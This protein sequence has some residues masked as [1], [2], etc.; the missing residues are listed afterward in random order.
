MNPELARTPLHD[1][2]QAHH[3]RMVE[4]GGW[5]MPVQYQSIMEEH[6]AVRTAVGLFDV[7]HMGRLAFTGP[8]AW[9]FLDRVLTRRVLDLPAGRVR[10]SLVTATSG[11]ILDDVLVY[12][13]V[14]ELGNAWPLLVVNASNR[15][16]LW[17]WFCALGAE[18]PA[19]GIR[20]NTLSTAMIAVQGPQAMELVGRVAASDLRLQAGAAS[21]AA[22]AA[23]A[24]TPLV[25]QLRA[26]PSYGVR[27]GRW[28]EWP[29]LV[30]RTGYTGEDGLELI[31]PA[32]VAVLIWQRLAEGGGRPVGLGAR[33]T[34]RLEAAMPLYGHELSEARDP[35]AADLSFAVQLE[36]RHFVGSEALVARRQEP[37]GD[38]RVGVV[39]EGKR[40]AREGYEVLVNGQR[41]GE[42]T[43]GTF[44]P[45]L[46]RS[47]AMAYVQ[48]DYAAVGQSLQ[49]DIRGQLVA[50]TV[51]K[52]PFYRRS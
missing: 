6:Q 24:G 9:T 45:T 16:K 8:Q 1:W 12:H 19:I 4:F 18:D 47:L 22:G 7:S 28:G 37:A 20:D 27:A 11:G 46:Q 44:S 29:L 40:V 39:L 14:G 41:V 23:T 17:A 52:L 25:E 48:R 38:V 33:D 50:A 51:V 3:G 43:S 35:F 5:S 49:V 15:A 42:V 10:Y 13:V 2:H 31:V 36:G 26:I 21:A 30:S 34:L 32:A